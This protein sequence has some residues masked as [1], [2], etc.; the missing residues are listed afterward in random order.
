MGRQILLYLVDAA[1]LMFTLVYQ[2]RGSGVFELRLSSFTN[3]Y[4]RDFEGNCCSG[5]RSTQGSCS[6]V[7]RTYFRVC[8]KHYQAT[9]DPN[10]PCTFGEVVTPV[11]G[12]NSVHLLDKKIHGFNNP[13]R[14]AFSFSWPGT[15]SLIVEAWHDSLAG[16]EGRRT[17]IIRLATQRYL[18]VTPEWTQDVHR[19][20]HT[21]MEY[22]YRVVCDYTYYGETCTKLCRPRDDKFGHYT[23]SPTGE[24]ICLS[25]WTGDYCSEAV[26][27][28]GCH[29]THGYC[30]QPNECLCR[31]GWQGPTCQ[32]CT[33]YPGCVHGTCTEPWQCTCEEGW[34]GLFCNQ[35][36]NY[37]TNHK[38]CKNGGTCTN[39]G[40]GSYTCTCPEG[41]TG[42]ACEAHVDDCT[43]EPCLNG[44][45]CKGNGKNYTCHCPLGYYGR[46]CETSAST[47]TENPC[48]NGG[49]CVDQPSGYRC[50]C[51][52]GFSG[53]KC[54]IQKNKC[55]PN[56]CQNGGSCV[57]Q[58]DGYTCICRTGF[59]GLNCEMDIN[60]CAD[61]PCLNGGTCVDDVNYFHCS[62]V[63]GFI[64]SLCQTNVDD[65]LTKPCANG[66]TCQDLV[67]DFQCLCQPGFTSKDCS[68]EV[69]ECTSNPCQGGG[70]C[71]DRVNDFVCVCPSGFG[72]RLCERAM[73]SSAQRVGNII[74]EGQK[75]YTS[76]STA[77]SGVSDEDKHVALIGTFSVIVPLL[78]IIAVVTTLLLRQRKHREREKRDEEAMRKQ[79]ELN[80]MH[81]ANKKCLDN[82]IINTFERPSS[83]LLNKSTDDETS[84][85]FAKEHSLPC[86]K[87]TK[88]HNTD[89]FSSRVL[90]T[91]DSEKHLI[92]SQK[93]PEKKQ[94]VQQAEPSSANQSEVSPHT[95]TC[96][97]S[98]IYVIED[99]YV[100]QGHKGTLATEV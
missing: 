33:R 11:L 59:T 63:P 84:A 21:M 47:C 39:T 20:N 6:S 87:S 42:P 41:F 76:P 77:V 45:T 10:P 85:V 37:C 89:W 60:D 58:S 72:G 54:E 23:C 5:Y 27:S 78:A 48:H 16:G 75:V 93:T 4:G 65:C 25:G 90:D 96:P 38:P 55:E 56:Q 66:G 67:N 14:F 74:T 12:N 3:N 91:I 79:N 9:I 73:G 32:E 8:L 68:V 18:Q 70:T 31:Q 100:S 7:C 51:A 36:L 26:C 92:N 43:H 53:E 46:N 1:L 44:G 69:D 30:T 40:H 97:H 17:L 13:I 62:C 86:T 64:G 99:H 88:L 2:T 94:S 22:S 15:F 28:L 29:K 80:S 19:T 35:D 52:K 49:S 83:K 61:N 24:K 98:S 95:G 34:G 50:F 71:V 81:S 57:D 82:Q